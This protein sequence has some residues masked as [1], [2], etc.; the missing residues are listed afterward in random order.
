MGIE[1]SVK[2]SRIKPG[3]TETEKRRAPFSAI[4]T[5]VRMAEKESG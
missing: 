5:F 3:M 4:L 2:G 1:Q